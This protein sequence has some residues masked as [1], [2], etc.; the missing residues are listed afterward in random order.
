[1]ASPAD[2]ELQARE[3]LERVTVSIYDALRAEIDPGDGVRVL[4]LDELPG[5]EQARW[6]RAVRGLLIRDEIRVGKRPS[7]PV[8]M[9]GQTTLDE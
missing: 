6:R 8:Q 4:P 5:E 3:D 1:V 2:R 9:A 7:V